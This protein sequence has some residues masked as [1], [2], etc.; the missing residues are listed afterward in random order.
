MGCQ[1]TCTLGVILNDALV[2]K[3]CLMYKCMVA[4]EATSKDSTGRR[5]SMKEGKSKTLNQAVL[6]L[7]VFIIYKRGSEYYLMTGTK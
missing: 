4:W 7:D 2:Y 1:W 6:K 3:T 5:S